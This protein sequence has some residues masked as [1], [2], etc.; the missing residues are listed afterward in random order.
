M[1]HG[2]VICEPLS[3]LPVQFASTRA[4]QG[5]ISALLDQRVSKQEIVALRDDQGAADQRVACVTGV[6][7]EPTQ[8]AP[9]RIFGR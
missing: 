2:V 7:E 1:K 3:G 9:D 6:V 8:Q 5:R 4:E